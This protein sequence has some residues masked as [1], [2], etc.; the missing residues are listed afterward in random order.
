M[1]RAIPITLL[2]VV[3]CSLASVS[4]AGERLT[5]SRKA[6]KE[7]AGELK[8]ELIAALEGGGPT[9][10]VT[11]CSRKAPEI[12]DRISS[13][14]GWEVG[15]TSL[16][17]RN[18]GNEPDSWE[19]RTLEAFEERRAK[20][21]D[22]STMENSEVLAEGGRRVFRYMKAIPTGDVCLVCHGSNIAEPLK[23]ELDKL[24]PGDRARGFNKGD[25]RGAF[26]V[27]QPLK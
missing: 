21:E 7:F 9:K 20:R 19:R 22:L 25:I 12:A 24:Y 3:C 17:V 27:I 18:P 10:A 16:R 1:L 8:K 11:V 4:S 26:T 23:A 14:R 15:R 13:D 5:E 2:L 6:V